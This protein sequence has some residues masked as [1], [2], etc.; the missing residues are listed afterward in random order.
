MS[1]EEKII[2]SLIE[3]VDLLSQYTPASPPNPLLPEI[4]VKVTALK[5]KRQKSKLRFAKHF[6]DV[7]KLLKELNSFKT[8]F[9]E[10][11]SFKNFKIQKFTLNKIEPPKFNKLENPTIKI[12][13]NIKP[14][15]IKVE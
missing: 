8:S 3:L 11:D 2:D 9:Q 4:R 14:P 6:L 5:I 1:E 7:G 15:A 10:L 12:D 13:K